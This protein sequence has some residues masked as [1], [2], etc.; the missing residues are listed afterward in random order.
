[1]ED[2]NDGGPVKL[3]AGPF[4]GGHRRRWRSRDGGFGW[5]LE[6]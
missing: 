3:L 4:G 5:C 2:G 6:E 1:M